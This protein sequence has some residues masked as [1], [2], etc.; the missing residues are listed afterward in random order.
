MNRK[1]I[2]LRGLQI[3][4]LFAI[5]L[6][7]S[8][9]QARASITSSVRFDDTK[10]IDAASWNP[11]EGARVTLDCE[12][13]DGDS[14]TVT[15]NTD[16]QGEIETL[17]TSQMDDDE[18][19]EGKCG[20]SIS[21]DGYR[22]FNIG[23]E[24]KGHIYWEGKHSQ[25]NPSLLES[26][27][28]G[29]IGL[30]L[31]PK[32]LGIS[33]LVAI[34]ATIIIYHWGTKLWCGA[35]SFF[36]GDGCPHTYR[37]DRQ[38]FA[39]EPESDS[40]SVR[41]EYK[42][43]SEINSD[44]YTGQVTGRVTEKTKHQLNEYLIGKG[45]DLGFEEKESQII[46]VAEG[47]P[48]DDH[49][50]CII[51]PNYPSNPIGTNLKGEMYIE[52][53]R[54]AGD[55]QIMPGHTYLF[56]VEGTG[57]SDEYFKITARRLTDK[58]DYEM[59]TS[60]T[61]TLSNTMGPCISSHQQ[62]KDQERILNEKLNSYPTLKYGE[63]Y[64]P[65][66]I[67]GEEEGAK[68]IA[69]TENYGDLYCAPGDKPT[70]GEEPDVRIIPDEVWEEHIYNMDETYLSTRHYG[71]QHDIMSARSSDELRLDPEENET[72]AEKYECGEDQ[73]EKLYCPDGS[74]L[75]SEYTSGLRSEYTCAS[76]NH[77]VC[78]KKEISDDMGEVCGGRTTYSTRRGREVLIPNFCYEGDECIDFDK[79]LCSSADY[80]EGEGIEMLCEVQ[81]LEGKIPCDENF[82]PGT[83]IDDK[84]LQRTPNL[85]ICGELGSYNERGKTC[86]IG[87]IYDSK[88][89][90]CL[91]N[92]LADVG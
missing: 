74:G 17:E 80:E 41:E 61:T 13:E 53:N 82:E 35:S 30:A 92:T 45:L 19:R 72:Y 89:G 50:N 63:T 2:C 73:G 38:V 20:I 71:S 37:Y 43:I 59:E 51:A 32:T 76:E 54:E 47:I 64:T 66:Y 79:R 56:T 46:H 21:A 75:L 15:K 68:K 4:A 28:W 52:G 39:L 36:G 69:E 10:V 70:S 9:P 12:T 57:M 40:E 27:A 62:S 83:E 78:I 48:G 23:R 31:A 58:T 87:S 11:I 7:V 44:V 22:D 49:S 86:P 5:T 8:M 90:K 34:V 60:P 3:I 88:T 65:S 24:D 84:N 6:M 16:D 26:S 77:S 1:K 18:D 14:D 85:F 81:N 42:T 67:Y 55:I 91:I 29:L 25:W 33:I